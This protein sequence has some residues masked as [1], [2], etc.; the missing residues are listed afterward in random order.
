M[1]FESLYQKFR[2]ILFVDGQYDGRQ[3]RSAAGQAL[4]K[5]IQETDLPGFPTFEEKILALRHGLRDRPVCVVCGGR[6]QRSGRADPPFRR[7]CSVSC[8]AH[9]PQ[10]KSQTAATL[11]ARYGGHHTQAAEY[12]EAAALRAQ[13]NGSYARGQ[14]TFQERY[15]ARSAFGLKK[16]QDKI[17]QTN[18]QRYGHANPM[19]AHDIQA[20]AR[21]TTL[22]RHGAFFNPEKTKQTVKQKWGVENPMQC[23]EIKD[24][25]RETTLQ[26]HGAFFNPEKMQATMVERYG[27]PHP[28][29]CREIKDRAQRIYRSTVY[30]RIISRLEDKVKPLFTLEEFYSVDNSLPWQCIS[31]SRTFDSCL[32]DGKVPRCLSC[33]PIARRG[34]ENEIRDIL[35]QRYGLQSKSD[36]QT[37]AGREIDIFFKQRNIGIEVNG[38]YWHSSIFKPKDFHQQKA[39]DAMSAGVQLVHIFEHDWHANQQQILAHLDA[40][41]HHDISRIAARACTVRQ[42]TAAEAAEFIDSHHL[43]GNCLGSRVRLGIYHND[44]LEGVMTFGAPRYNKQYEWELLR[45]CTRSGRL[46]VGGGSKLLKYFERHWQPTSLISYANL[47]HS[48]GGIYRACG[49]VQDGISPP[50][51]FYVDGQGN[52]VSRSGA[53]KQLLNKKLGNPCP[54]LS[55]GE[56][57]AELGLLKIYNSGNLKFVK[58]YAVDNK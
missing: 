35:E 52:T 5:Q 19:V 46:V 45:Y 3:F 26:R 49:F 55:E 27:V 8:A 18:L 24:R 34:L 57:A 30:N 6:V 10:R 37:L 14:Q 56:A 13:T 47:D 50:G 51:Y 29:Q 33:N 2:D 44:I 21:E 31:C 58:H 9:D 17:A 36:R 25:A 43:S 41:F 16:T 20:R 53:T 48:T 38:T 54:A 1:D 28:M 39:L 32:S 11:E 23:S 42:V 15:G 4:K 7:T 22:Q 40:L 12:K